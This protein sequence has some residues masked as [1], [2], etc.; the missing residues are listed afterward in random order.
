MYI[1]SGV[2]EQ[3]DLWPT[4]GTPEFAALWTGVS[5]TKSDPQVASPQMWRKFNQWPTSWVAVLPKLNG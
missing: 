4:A 2:P 3:V 1:S 5:A